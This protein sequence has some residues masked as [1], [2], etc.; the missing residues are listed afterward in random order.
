V[1]S[2]TTQKETILAN[3]VDKNRHQN[4]HIALCLLL[5]WAKTCFNQRH[6]NIVLG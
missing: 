6:S 3:R 1:N 2:K 5:L 4:Q